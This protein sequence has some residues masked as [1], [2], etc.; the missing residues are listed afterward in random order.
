[1]YSRHAEELLPH[2]AVT[3]GV[4]CQQV[5]AMTELEVD[6]LQSCFHFSRLFGLSRA[7]LPHDVLEQQA[8]LADPLHRLEQV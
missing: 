3:D 7:A 6:D 2:I 1:M 5:V 4:H 8:V